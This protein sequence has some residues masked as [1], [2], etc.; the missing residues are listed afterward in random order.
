MG[1]SVGL[2]WGQTESRVEVRVGA[3][4]PPPPHSRKRIRIVQRICSG[5]LGAMGGGV[6]G[7]ERARE[8]HLPQRRHRHALVAVV[9]RY[10]LERDDIIVWRPGVASLEDGAVGSLSDLCDELEAVGDALGARV[11]ARRR[12]ARRTLRAF[13]HALEHEVPR[14]NRAVGQFVSLIGFCTL[15]RS[16]T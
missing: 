4:L 8:T 13:L 2:A 14:K 16:C 3:G 10:L 5:Y 11:R 7:G 15:I 12:R 1:V 9:E 6:G